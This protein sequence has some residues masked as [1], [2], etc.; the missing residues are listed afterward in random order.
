M[1]KME[2]LEITL[3]EKGIISRLTNKTFQFDKKLGEG[4]YAANYFLKTRKVVEKYCPNHQ[5]TMQFFQ[6]R[7]EAMLCGVDEAIALIHTFAHNPQDLLIEALNDG[8]IIKANEP[9]LKITGKYEDFGFLESMIDGI[10]ARRTS[11]ATNVYETLKVANN[12]PIFSMADRQDDYLT[13]VGDGYATYVAGINKVSTDAQGKWWGGKGMGTMPH[14]IFHFI[15]QILKPKQLADERMVFKLA[16]GN[17]ASSLGMVGH[18]LN[19]GFVEK[20]SS[21]FCEKNG[22]FYTISPSYIQFVNLCDYIMQHNHQVTETFLMKH[23][24]EDVLRL[25]SPE[26]VEAYKQ[27]ERT[28]Y[29]NN[30]KLKLKDGSYR[31]IKP[32]EIVRSFNQYVKKDEEYSKR[33]KQIINNFINSTVMDFANKIYSTYPYSLEYSNVSSY[34]EYFKSIFQIPAYHLSEEEWNKIIDQINEKLGKFV[35]A[36]IKDDEIRRAQCLFGPHRDDVSFYINDI[37]A[38]RYASQGQQRTLV[39][40]LKLAELD[41]IKEKT[42]EMPLLLL[43]D[44]LAELDNVRQNYLLNAI[45]DD[46]QTIITSVDTIAFDKEFLSDVDIVKISNGQII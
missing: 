36:L 18:M 25:C 19:E 16:D 29:A 37:D 13:Q 5:V 32:E 27:T 35:D 41:V 43:D 45:G 1:N 22:I 15:F 46:T 21:D 2:E 30:F 33:K 26:V 11:V 4:F 3:K 40:A 42:G 44:V 12:V 20:L 7:S 9:V 31:E 38:K 10:L 14:E 34:K 24:Y 39:L 17:T 28:E 8:D 23:N 6:R